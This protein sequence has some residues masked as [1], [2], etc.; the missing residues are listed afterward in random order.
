MPNL[1]GV[2]IARRSCERTLCR[3]AGGTAS[4]RPRAARLLYENA[5]VQSKELFD[6]I[7]TT[8]SIL[9]LKLPTH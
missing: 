5:V 4:R 6:L 1:S 7:L 8:R 2:E 3:Q 9:G